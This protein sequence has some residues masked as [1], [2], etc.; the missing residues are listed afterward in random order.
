MS[1]QNAMLEHLIKGQDN[2]NARIA[3]LS[4]RIGDLISV[5]SARAERESQQEKINAEVIQ[6][7]KENEEPLSRLRRFHKM[8]DSWMTKIVG[9]GIFAIVA[10]IF[11]NGIDLTKIGGAG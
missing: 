3:E 11:I 10:Y 9:T 5:E 1:E 8:F 6:F 4:E 2:L 7:I